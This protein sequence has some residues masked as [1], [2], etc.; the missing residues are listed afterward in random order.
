MRGDEPFFEAT[1]ISLSNEQALAFACC[2]DEPGG[3][4]RCGD[5]SI[6]CSDDGH[7]LH[8]RKQRD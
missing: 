7:P 6:A 2:E 3:A 5:E 8:S 4:M 1:I